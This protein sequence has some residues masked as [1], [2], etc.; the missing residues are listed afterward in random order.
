MQHLSHIQLFITF[1]Q[2]AHMLFTQGYWR[3]SLKITP[4]TSMDID[5]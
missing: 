2:E 4:N 1:Y 3:L 5:F